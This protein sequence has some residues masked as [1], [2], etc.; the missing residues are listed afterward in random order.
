MSELTKAKKERWVQELKRLFVQRL[1]VL[2]L[3]SAFGPE[4]VDQT[5]K[6]LL[7]TEVTRLGE[8]GLGES[9]IAAVFETLKSWMERG[10]GLTFLHVN[11]GETPDF[12]LIFV[13]EMDADPVVAHMRAALDKLHTDN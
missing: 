9:A 1:L 7:T 11:P 5:M 12:H 6:A 10:Y 2:Y 4:W 8:L 13:D 3:G